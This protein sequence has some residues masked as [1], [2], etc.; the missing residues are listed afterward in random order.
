MR[1]SD[2]TRTDCDIYLLHVEILEQGA[3][4]MD[5]TAHAG[6]QRTRS[7]QTLP[8]RDWAIDYRN[9]LPTNRYDYDLFVMAHTNGVDGRKARRA[10]M[11]LGRF[12][13]RITKRKI[14]ARGL[15]YLRMMGG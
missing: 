8:M 5:H 12:Y 9:A 3:R 1:P 10:S 7:T 6:V 2:L 15:A 11:V 4:A 14:Y 13:N